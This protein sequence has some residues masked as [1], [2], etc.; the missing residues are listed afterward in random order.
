M[1]DKEH[2]TDGEPWGS[3]IIGWLLFNRTVCNAE[4]ID[5]GTAMG[6]D[7]VDTKW[8]EKHGVDLYSLSGTSCVSSR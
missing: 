8:L 2:I 7:V 4:L 5:Q 1:S 3:M 6:T